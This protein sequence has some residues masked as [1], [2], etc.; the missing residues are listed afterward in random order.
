MITTL[1]AEHANIVKILGVAADHGVDSAA[2]RETLMTAKVGLLAHLKREDEDLYPALVEAAKD[3]PI[4]ADALDVLDED[5]R[6]L[7]G[8][9]LA[10]FDKAE[11]SDDSIA[12]DFG[13]LVALLS[14]RIQKEEAV[15]YKAY[16]MLDAF[17]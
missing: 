6:G 12:E 14:R 1:K 9:A 17:E 16:D 3:D 2:G 13:T 10:F 8:Q 15:I 4:V 5:M 11:T 7:A